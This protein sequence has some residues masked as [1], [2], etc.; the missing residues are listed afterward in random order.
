MLRALLTLPRPLN[1]LITFASVLLGGWLA[2]PT[3][4]P[5]LLLAACSA[6]LLTGGGNALNDLCDLETDRINKPE[7]PLPSGRVSPLLV[8]L[9]AIVLLILGLLAGFFLPPSAVAIAWIAVCGLILYNIRLKRVPLL[10]NFLVSL[11]G[12][13]AFLYG[14]T[15]VQAPYPA[16]IPAI[17]ALFYHLGREILKDVEDTQGDPSG[18]TLALRWGKRNARMLATA[19]FSLLIL[20]TPLPVYLGFYGT[21]YLALVFLLNLLLVYIL[22]TLWQHPARL[23]HLNQLLKIGMVL[24]LS[25]IF[26]DR[27]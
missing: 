24:G 21:P 11:L 26:F 27:L 3:L 6:A 15:A 14:G 8:R 1:C 10:G 22:R 23:P 17:F 2:V 5:S 25:A 12:S 19:I 7:R 13:L 16:T 4:P 20:I 9:E 18:S